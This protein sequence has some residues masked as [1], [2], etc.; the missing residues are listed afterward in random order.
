MFAKHLNKINLSIMV[1]LDNFLFYVIFSFLLASCGFN[2][3]TSKDQQVIT[4]TSNN[5]TNRIDS[6]QFSCYA[7]RIAE[8]G[9]TIKINASLLNQSSDTLYFLSSTCD[10]A[11]YSLRFDTSNYS[12]T[13]RINCNA[14]Y[15]IIIN[16][17]P[18]DHYDFETYFSCKGSEKQI[19][20]GFDFYSVE[21]NAKVTEFSLDKIVNGSQTE[22]NI[23]WAEEVNID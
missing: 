16:L 5:N 8:F 12:L 15:P 14:S 13:P 2:T 7:T 20:L 9:N 4:N 23:L 3:T 11:Q 10:G 21:K 6:I 19:K 1:K 17:N 18:N 22:Q